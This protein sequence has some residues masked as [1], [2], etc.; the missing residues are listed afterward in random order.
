MK[1]FILAIAA[2]LAIGSLSA[3]ADMSSAGGG[4]APAHTAADSGMPPTLNDSFH[5]PSSD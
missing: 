1:R 2:V 5:Y 3:C 4:S